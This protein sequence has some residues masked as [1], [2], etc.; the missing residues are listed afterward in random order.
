MS[1]SR[2]VRYGMVGGGPGGFVGAIHRKA[3]ALDGN[4]EIVSGVFSS[5]PEKSYQAGRELFLDP[6]R[7]YGS[8]REMVEKEG[9]LSEDK[10]IDFVSIVTPNFLHFSIAKAFIEAGINIVCDKP[11]VVSIEEADELCSLV[12]KK[13]II[14]AVTYNYTGYPMVKQA[15][16]MIKK[17]VL[18]EL[19]KVIVEYS[20]D[21]LLRMVDFQ[22][23]SEKDIWRMIPEKSGRSLAIG[24]IGSHAENLASY[25]TAL[26][27][28]SLNALTNSYTQGTGLDDEANILIRYQNGVRGILFCS[29]VAAGEMNNLNIRVYGNK[30]SLEWKEIEPNYFIMRFPGGPEK[31]Y[32]R[33]SDYLEPIAKYNIRFPAGLPEGYLEA[34]ANVYT[35]VANTIMARKEGKEPHEF[36]L[37][38]P[39]IIDG[40]RGVYF[41]NRAVDS[42]KNNNWVNMNFN[43]AKYYDT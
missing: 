17:G 25:I 28:E 42:G 14:F 33:D 37:D 26:E 38:F 24:D 40:A 31:I 20:S 2:K 39:T 22:G 13:D 16:E 32:H 4:I 11:L 6:D 19:Q 1:L 9:N 3:A 5:S 36:D 29:V 10:K 15:R 43:P 12:A 18:G 35:H 7:V 30:A 34:F 41:I 23:K 21:W 8:Y 27:M